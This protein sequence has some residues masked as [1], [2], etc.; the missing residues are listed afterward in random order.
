MIN[1]LG[2]FYLNINMASNF[3]RSRRRRKPFAGGFSTLGQ[4]I[5]S[6]QLQHYLA[7]VFIGICVLSMSV[8]TNAVAEPE[9]AWQEGVADTMRRFMAQEG[10]RGQFVAQDGLQVR[11]Q[12]FDEYCGDVAVVVLTGWSEPFLK[13]AEVIYDLRQRNYCVYTMDH[14]GQGFS[15][16]V[17]R[18]RQVGHVE[19]F[20]HYVDDLSRFDRTVVRSRRHERVYILAHSMGG[21]VATLYAAQTER[22]LH[23]LILVA[24][25]F[26]INTG[27]WPEWAA[28]TIVRAFNALGYG[29][30]YAPGESDWSPTPFA[31][32]RLT[33]SAARYEFRSDL[34]REFPDI[35]LGGVS[36]RWVQTAIEHGRKVTELAPQINMP[37]LLFQAGDDAFVHA[38]R[39]NQFC[40]LAQRCRKIYFPDAKHELLMEKDEFRNAVFA[41][42]EQFIETAGDT[43]ESGIH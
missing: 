28:H 21:L 35:V 26:A 23:G 9:T 3:T 16:R 30:R 25:M 10:Q 18:N 29:Q 17:T 40:E 11:Y 20:S 1:K 33:H 14:R 38:D 42:I 7:T 15:G 22:D 24:P 6:N 43:P 31:E 8:V 37:M 34:L 39:Q 32:N 13:Y 5:Y 12:R 36:N 4:A 41:A 19:N 2:T 27:V